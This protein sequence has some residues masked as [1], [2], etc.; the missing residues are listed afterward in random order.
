[1]NLKKGDLMICST[2]SRVCGIKGNLMNYWDIAEKKDFEEEV[3]HA[4]TDGE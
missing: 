3:G 2:P 4:V 1:M